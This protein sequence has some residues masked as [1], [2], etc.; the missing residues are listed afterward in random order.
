MPLAAEGRWVGVCE[1]LRALVCG[2]LLFLSSLAAA[3][4]PQPAYSP[5]C[6]VGKGPRDHQAWAKP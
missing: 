2:G 4:L 3:P 1:K 5:L 6:H